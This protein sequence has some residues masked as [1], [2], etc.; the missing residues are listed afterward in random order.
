MSR[1][2]ASATHQ[3]WMGDRDLPLRDF[4]IRCADSLDEPDGPADRSFTD[5]RDVFLDAGLTA[6]VGTARRSDWVQVGLVVPPGPV[7]PDL[8]RR[9]AA[10]IRELLDRGDVRNAFFMHKPPGLRLR[11]EVAGP[12]RARVEHDIYDR[13]AIWRV[14][15]AVYEPET[16]LFGGP[17]SMRS[18]HRL[19]TLDALAWLDH[20][21]GPAD[22]G[23]AGP[24]WAL[25]LLM[26]RALFDGLEIV[27]WE[28]I[29]VWD[30]VRSRGGR[31]L[32]PQALA[33]DDLARVADQVRTS[34]AGPD[35]L[36]AQLPP[37]TRRIAETYRAA[38]LPVAARWRADYFAT[39][40]AYVGPREAAAYFTIFHWN[41]AAFVPIRQA[42]LTEALA[43][44]RAG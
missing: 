6:L 26:L 7:D 34:W 9:L 1:G 37:A 42:L 14:E 20:H 22:A 11:F 38:V 8:Y 10:I 4:L 43:D 40:Q 41:R 5:A 16:H 21:G 32:A 13:L 29:D 23:P 17:V 35:R 2:V 33:H 19:F 15:P 27:G 28:D 39:R 44:R 3:V 36:L 18:V 24:P 31:R 30:R 12:D 25:S